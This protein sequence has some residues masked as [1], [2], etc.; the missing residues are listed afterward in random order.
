LGFVLIV[1]IPES[2]YSS[3]SV[4]CYEDYYTTIGSFN[5]VM[6]VTK[7]KNTGFPPAFYQKHQV[8]CGPVA[9]HNKRTNEWEPRRNF[10]FQ[11]AFITDVALNVMDI[12]GI[13]PC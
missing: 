9:E 11:Y 4:F 12:V 2:C 7:T 13:I 6:D 1:R 8:I 5:Y 10:P 3:F